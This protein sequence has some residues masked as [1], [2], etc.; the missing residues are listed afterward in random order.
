MGNVAGEFR[1]AYVETVRIF[2]VN[3]EDWSVDCIS[4]HG[5]KRFFDVQVM[6]PY[7]HFTNG[8]G[9][10][11]MPEVG[12]LAYL[13]TPSSGRMVP[14]FLMGFQAP[15]DENSIN[16][17]SGRPNLNP[18]DIMLRT[19]DENFVALRRGGVVQ[20]GS[21]AIAQRLYVPIRNFIKDF[22]E[23]YRLATFAGEMFWETDR[24]DQTKEGDAPTRLHLKVKQK[25]NDPKHV[26]TLTMGS[27][28]EDDPLTMDLTIW[29]DG[30]SE[31]EARVSLQ[32]SNEGDVTWNLEKDWTQNVVGNHTTTVE[33]DY[34]V[35]A[36][37][38]AGVVS[39]G[40]AT[41]ESGANLSLAAGA[42]ADVTAGSVATVDAPVI[43]LG[44]AAASQA[45]KGTELHL[46]LKT[47]AQAQAKIAANPAS[48][49]PAVLVPGYEALALAL[50]T[51]LSS[52][53]KVE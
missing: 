43:N 51:I 42:N 31:Q 17:R 35:E 41:V 22:C 1:P 13:C 14:A 29:S 53:V 7:F 16:Y 32:I 15:F 34:S 40:D 30:T 44:G 50:D 20:I 27:H 26:A 23:N 9:I 6:T 8:E 36:Q 19:R 25:A 11:V 28:E 12:A 48:L 38:T 10:Y 5:N 18:G 52:K 49:L 24:D 45:V 3:I 21:T 33:G 2:N 46:A 47:F 39:Q 4:E 37:G